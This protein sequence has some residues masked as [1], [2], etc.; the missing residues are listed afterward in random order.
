LALQLVQI[1]LIIPASLANSMIHRI[2][3][4]TL[5][6]QGRSFGQMMMIMVWMG[7]VCVSSFIIFAPHIIYFVSGD[8]YLTTGF[9]FTWAGVQTIFANPSILTHATIGA[10]I[11]LPVLAIVLSLSFVKTVFNYVF[12]AAK[13]QNLLFPINLIGVIIG[14]VAAF[15]LVYH[16]TIVG[17]MVAQLFMELLF[18]IG[19]WFYARKYRILPVISWSDMS[20]M[21]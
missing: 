4:A 11:V 14:G 15:V 20:I 1:L 2:S 5:N 12:V 3:A 21:L 10:D 18:V 16:Y 8:K 6:Q 17:G 7:M 13:K 19:S 9:Q